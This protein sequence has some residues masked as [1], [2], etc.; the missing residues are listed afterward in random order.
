VTQP[1][2]L[3][4]LQNAY[5]KGRLRAGER[6]NPASW[7]AE[8]TQSSTGRRLRIVLNS[9]DDLDIRYCN[10]AP[11]IGKGSRSKLKACPKHVGKAVRRA[12]PNLVLACG[13]LA[14][15]TV[16]DLWEGDLIVMPH[17]AYMFLTQDL[18]L[19]A[20][21]AIRDW[22][23]SYPRPPEVTKRIALRQKR[24]FVLKEILNV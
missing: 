23:S 10:A 18:L 24:G 19:Q 15:K 13:E 12:N 16:R 21:R 14:E 8:F 7:R 5:D 20:R 3:V 1:T 4:V 2:L 6:F 17:P 11:G 22:K 9:H